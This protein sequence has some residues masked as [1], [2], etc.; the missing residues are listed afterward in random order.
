[1][2]AA[3]QESK[4][5]SIKKTRNSKS[6]EMRVEYKRSDFEELRRGKFCQKVIAGS[7]AVV[8]DRKVATAFPTSAIA[9]TLSSLL[10]L[11]KKSSGLKYCAHRKIT[12]TE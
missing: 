9:P 2:H 5:N 4:G 11:A 7:N 3:P 10:E 12:R 6:D 8:L 1:M